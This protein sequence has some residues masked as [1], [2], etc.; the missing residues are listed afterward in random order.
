MRHDAP[1]FYCRMILA[2]VRNRY[3]HAFA[4][5]FNEVLDEDESRERIIQL[6]KISS[7]RCC[8]FDAWDGRHDI[9][10]TGRLSGFTA[11]RKSESPLMGHA[12]LITRVHVSR[13]GY[14]AKKRARSRA[15]RA[16]SARHDRLL[17]A[18]KTLRWY[19]LFRDS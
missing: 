13:I 10:S 16:S 11:W 17:I 5:R 14:E 12:W 3:R 19:K 15:H 6:I 18:I 4:W 1:K 9:W 2:G 8:A 7:C